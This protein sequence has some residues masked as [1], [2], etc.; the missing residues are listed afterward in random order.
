MNRQPT[1]ARGRTHARGEHDDGTWRLPHEH[2]ESADSQQA[3]PIPEPIERQAHE[4]VRRGLVD[5]DR[6]PV[7]DRLYNDRLVASKRARRR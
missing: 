1:P 2:D 5:T 7:M 3:R 4:D 6:G